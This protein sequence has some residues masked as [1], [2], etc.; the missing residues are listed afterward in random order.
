MSCLHA[1]L[2]YTLLTHLLSLCHFM[3]STLLLPLTP[4]IPSQP[5]HT[6]PSP[7]PTHHCPTPC[8]RVAEVID[9][10]DTPLAHATSV[11]GRYIH[12]LVVYIIYSLWLIYSSPP[13]SLYR[14]ISG[15]HQQHQQQQQQQQQQ[16]QQQQLRARARCILQV[17]AEP[18]STEPME[19]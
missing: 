13:P 8:T 2:H 19:Y 1:T 15:S 7:P 3:H 12:A 16:L 6:N 5:T 10:A 18:C 4:C 11:G 9:V 14:T 17:A